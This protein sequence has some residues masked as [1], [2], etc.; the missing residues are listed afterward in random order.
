MQLTAEQQAILA[1]DQDLTIEAAA[2]AGKT[3]TLLEYAASRPPES[4][5]LY[6]AFN[7]ITKEEAQM[8]V[9]RKNLHNVWVETAHALAYRLMK[10][11]FAQPLVAAL[12]L[13]QL[14][15]ALDTKNHA[16]VYHALQWA[17]AFCHSQEKKVAE[18]PYL[19]GLSERNSFDFVCKYEAQI[20]R[21]ARLILAFQEQGKL[22]LTHD[23]YLK[24]YQLSNPILNFD[25]ILF[26]EGQDA[27]P[28]MLD[29]FFRQ[30]AKKILVGDSNQQIYSW[31]N[32][33]NALQDSPFERKFLTESFRFN[34][35]IAEKAQEIINWKK[36][37]NPNFESKNF[38]GAPQAINS[39][40]PDALIARTNLELLERAISE[41]FHKKSINRYHF[42]GDLASYTYIENGASILDLLQLRQNNLKAI[43]DPII[44]QMRSFE[45]LSHYANCTDEKQLKFLL[46]I[47]RKYGN[48]L[49]FLLK[50]LQ[51][52]H[53]KVEEKKWAE[54]VFATAHR[55]KGNEYRRVHLTADFIN[56]GQILTLKKENKLDL[57]TQEKIKE[58]INILYVAVTRAQEDCIFYD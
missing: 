14:K 39:T 33:I 56:K 26:D 20:L 6:L 16:S 55:A 49:P 47:V 32:A 58:E 13:W 37:G 18:V 30:K 27:S 11:Q 3:T 23:F 45:E 24:K 54:M 50:K 36:I 29:I 52:N 31:R 22:P 57:K 12:P 43:Q 4:L 44:R 15:A 10:K 42:E 17:T 28:V 19:E 2:G 48:E 25:Y 38:Q 21:Q 41:I 7:K 1:T 46:E 8:R 53:L 9:A 35:K 51:E 5:I 34:T 40:Q